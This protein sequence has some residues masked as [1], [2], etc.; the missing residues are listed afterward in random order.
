MKHNHPGLPGLA[1]SLKVI[2]PAFFLAAFLLISFP[3]SSMATTCSR[4]SDCFSNE[5]CAS[6][7]CVSLPDGGGQ[8][9][10]S[11]KTH[12]DCFSN[13]ICGGGVCIRVP[14]GGGRQGN[15]CKKNSDCFSHEFCASGVCISR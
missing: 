1:R 10:G 3:S 2:V 11:C 5:F 14:D 7:E 4:N 6:G 8:Q 9:G 12:S 15:Q 13:E